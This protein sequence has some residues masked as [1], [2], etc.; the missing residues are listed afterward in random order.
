MEVGQKKYQFVL[1]V[2]YVLLITV[3]F[4][5]RVTTSRHIRPGK[6]PCEETGYWC[7]YFESLFFV[8]LD[9]TAYAMAPNTPTERTVTPT[10]SP[11]AID[12]STNINNIVAMTR[13]LI[14]NWLVIW[15][16]RE[17]IVAVLA[18]RDTAYVIMGRFVAWREISRV[19]RMIAAF[20][21]PKWKLWLKDEKCG[22]F[23]FY[24][25]NRGPTSWVFF[26]D[27]LTVYG[28]G[29]KFY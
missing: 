21:M 20:I 13:V 14:V 10:S 2:P 19:S 17:Q 16:N 27:E 9:V 24:F 28:R 18:P 1:L 12:E 11:M 6:I 15:R 29:I 3:S 8:F 23:S 7:P 26:F 22:K 25:V 5:L 4:V